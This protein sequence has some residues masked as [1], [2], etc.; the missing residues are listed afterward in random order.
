MR[1]SSA[2][3]PSTDIA[4]RHGCDR[5]PAECSGIF[6]GT[7]APSQCRTHAPH[8]TFLL[9]SLLQWPYRVVEYSNAQL[10]REANCATDREPVFATADVRTKRRA[11]CGKTRRTH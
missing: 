11:R 10:W 8:R 9:R 7:D 3:V 1:T 5:R 6:A 4:N 2:A